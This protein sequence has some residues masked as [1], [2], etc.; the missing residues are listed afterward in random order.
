MARILFAITLTIV[1][2]LA[3]AGCGGGKSCVELCKNTCAGNTPM[4]EAQCKTQCDSDAADV[5]KMN[6]ESE[7]NSLLSC[8]GG[9][10]DADACSQD[11]VTTKCQKQVIAA[12]TCLT[13]YC[14]KNT[15]DP[16]CA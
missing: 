4:T 6:C 5:K 14:N 7:Y 9:L 2:S 8:I 15:A 3:L 10:S 16:I 13:I 11:A 1:G 12:S